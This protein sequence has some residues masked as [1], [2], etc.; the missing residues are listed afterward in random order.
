MF[1]VYPLKFRIHRHPDARPNVWLLLSAKC[2]HV[3]TVACVKHEMPSIDTFHA[4]IDQLEF[5][6]VIQTWSVRYFQNMMYS[7]CGAFW[8]LTRGNIAVA[9]QQIK[10]KRVIDRK[11]FLHIFILLLL[12]PKEIGICIILLFMQWTRLTLNIIILYYNW[13]V[14]VVDGY[15][16]LCMRINACTKETLF[17]QLYDRNHEM[18]KAASNSIL[19]T[20]RL[21]N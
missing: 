7:W 6:L 14:A 20:L 8:K 10:G 5:L 2:A 3:C 1:F 13:S 19:R 17:Q 12:R 21:K 11:G 16:S 4:Y 15:R 18:I 9:V